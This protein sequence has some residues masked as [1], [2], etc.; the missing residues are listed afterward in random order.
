MNQRL[1][2]S[3]VLLMM[4]TAPTVGA[5]HPTFPPP[6]GNHIAARDGDVVL[7]ENDASVGIVH[8]RE[9]SVRVVFN[10]DERWILLLVDYATPARA[11]D[12]RVDSAH[13]YRDVEGVWPFGAR[14]E[15][16]ATIDE[17]STVPQGGQGGM[18]IATP[19]GLVQLFAMQQQFRDRNAVAV[20]SYR[21]GGRSAANNLLFDEAER[22][23]VAE[24]RR[25][26]GTI[27]MPGP[28]GVTG[29]LSFGVSGGGAA[30]GPLPN[31]AVRVGGSVRPPV[32]IADVPPVL[33]EI[34]ARANVRGIVI[35]EV[36]VDVDGTV[37]DARVLRS[38]P[39]LDAAALE[40]VRQWRYEPTSI[41]GKPV[42]VIMTVSVAF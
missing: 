3:V 15:G 5:Q 24:L 34:A 18:G 6:S 40:A 28:G 27:R 41:D 35:L 33:P 7:V 22:W 30:V 14:W 10:T 39:L 32:K 31:G 20:L 21:G 19:D 17:Y 2:L 12:G 36:T 11:A 29:T 23:Y 38:I 4:S 1:L 37:K 26:D 42:P 8:R 16:R 9:A 25:N 13:H